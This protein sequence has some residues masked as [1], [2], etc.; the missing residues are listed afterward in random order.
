MMTSDTAAHDPEAPNENPNAEH[1]QSATVRD[2]LLSE[3]QIT[4]TNGTMAVSIIINDQP[5]RMLHIAL[6]ADDAE[7]F[8]DAIMR[9]VTN[10]RR[11]IHDNGTGAI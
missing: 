10:L 7:E 8:A 4:V 6:T 2:Y 1:K 5:E 3:R 9:K 11:G